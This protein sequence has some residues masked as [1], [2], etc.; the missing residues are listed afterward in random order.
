MFCQDYVI[1]LKSF[2]IS[3]MNFCDPNRQN[4]YCHGNLMILRFG[5]MI[6][7]MFRAFCVNI[8]RVL[9]FLS[10]LHFDLFLHNSLRR[11]TWGFC[12]HAFVYVKLICV[13]YVYIHVNDSIFFYV[14]VNIFFNPCFAY[15][16]ATF[17]KVFKFFYVFYL[18][19]ISPKQILRKVT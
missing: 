3:S 5:Y 1:F 14:F 6:I 13:F 8:L 16:W 2:R 18:R 12:V 19:S 7:S 10:F 17:F 15:I 9:R 11:V 4:K